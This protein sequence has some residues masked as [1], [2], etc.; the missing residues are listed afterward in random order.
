[1]NT[2]FTACTRDSTASIIGFWRTEDDYGCFSNWYPAEFKYAG[3]RYASVGQYMMYQKASTFGKHDLAEAIMRTDDPAECKK[4]GRTKF[5]EFDSAIWDSVRKQIVKRG[6]KAKFRQNEDML[7]ELLSTESALLAECSSYDTIWGIGIGIEDGTWH[8]VEKWKGR[9]LLGR[10][11]MEVR[12]ELGREKLLS[13][14]GFVQIDDTYY[15]SAIPEW[16]MRPCELNRIPPFHQAIHAYS[17]TITDKHARNAFLHAFS[18]AD[19][20]QMMETNM[21]GGLPA[22]GFYEMK[23]D[24]YDTARFLRHSDMMTDRLRAFCNRHIPM[25]R[26]IAADEKLRD[27]CGGCFANGSGGGNDLLDAYVYGCFLND[28]Y[29]IGMVIPHYD[30]LLEHDGMNDWV[31]RPTKELLEPLDSEHVQAC[32]SWHFRREHFVEYSLVSD[33]IAGGFMLLMLET[34]SEKLHQAT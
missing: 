4:L 28:A 13:E 29:D 22:A 8:N 26:A 32:I 18:L 27:W 9:N 19:C 33:S 34:L 17:D 2:Q 12:D 14:R 10:I 30:V 31:S 20:E 25:L 3:R 1:M 21:G 6:V 15:T 5:P 24:V 16:R 23:Q 11:L 7:A